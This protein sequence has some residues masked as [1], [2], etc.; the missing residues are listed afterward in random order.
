MKMKMKMNVRNC[1][2]APRSLAVARSRADT[3]VH[4]YVHRR[5]HVI[6]HERL[7]GGEEVTS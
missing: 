2:P 7:E 1:A 4:I 5:Y 3:W 6:H